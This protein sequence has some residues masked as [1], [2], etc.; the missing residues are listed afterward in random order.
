M[1]QSSEFEIEARTAKVYELIGESGAAYVFFFFHDKSVCAA[2]KL[3]TKNRAVASLDF[4]IKTKD[5]LRD[6]GVKEHGT[7]YQKG[8][9]L[10]KELEGKNRPGRS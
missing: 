10:L 7:T 2:K 1:S 4:K 9:L 6:C 8:V 3:A 5:A